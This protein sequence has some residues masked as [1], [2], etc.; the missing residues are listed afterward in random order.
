M[1]GGQGEEQM[2]SCA[3][4]RCKRTTATTYR[5]C[6]IGSV[7]M[8]DGRR[9]CVPY[10]FF[11]IARFLVTYYGSFLYSEESGILSRSFYASWHSVVLVVPSF[12]YVIH[13]LVVHNENVSMLYRKTF[14]VISTQIT[15]GDAMVFFF[16]DI[17][18]GTAY[19]VSLF[20]FD[21]WKIQTFPPLAFASV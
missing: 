4:G 3:L 20:L 2:G 5:P 11:R 15:D 1:D 9:L 18:R 14:K 13:V 10:F 7:S 6:P 8:I 12:V 19:T 17:L 16:E 21:P